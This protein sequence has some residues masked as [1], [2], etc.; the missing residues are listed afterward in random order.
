M[1]TGPGLDSV[2]PVPSVT[3]PARSDGELLSAHLAGDRYAFEELFQRH[4]AQLY[5][6]ARRRSPTVE[7]ARDAVQDAMLSAHRAA[8]SFRNDAPVSGW[9]HRIVLNAC[10]DRLRHSAI[11]PTVP[12]TAECFAAAA[13]PTGQLDTALVLRQALMRLPAEQR[14]AVLAVHLYGYSVSDAAAL[15]HVAEGTIKSRCARARARLAVLLARPA[16]DA[17]H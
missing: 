1:R 4:R 9:L 12:L 3:G 7:D 16:G 13:D 10:R 6:L 2:R 14:E 8:G 15:L 17:A 11:R 5:R